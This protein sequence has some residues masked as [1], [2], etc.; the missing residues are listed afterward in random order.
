MTKAVIFDL[1][2]T[3]YDE[4]QFVRN[5]FKKV[6]LYISQVY[7]INRNKAYNLLIRILHD[8]GR[9]KVFDLAL[10]RL[11]LPV[12]KQ[13]VAKLV[14]VYRYNNY[15]LK[16]FK[17]TTRALFHLR[18]KGYKMAL[19]TDGNCRVQR[20]KVS[21]LGIGRFFDC[22][23]YSRQYGIS[24]E[25]PSQFIYQKCLKKLEVEPYDAIYVGDNPYKDFIGAKKIGMQTIMIKTG[26]RKTAGF[27]S[28]YGAEYFVSSM[29][30]IL[31]VIRKL[32]KQ[33]EDNYGKHHKNS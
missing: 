15:K 32:G 4:M 18:R 21:L 28:G 8:Y 2:D 16:P 6:A 10:S 14:S 26:R 13:V 29:G 22:L 33:I 24:C 5:G 25:K 27:P 31:E 30:S 12:N 17:G 3:L 19:L 11:G 20:H 23:V 1:D 7:K 9:G